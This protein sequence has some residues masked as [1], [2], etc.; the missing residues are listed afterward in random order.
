MESDSWFVGC[1]Y[2]NCIEDPSNYFYDQNDVF[3]DKPGQ[4][5]C[6]FPK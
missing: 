3:R 5:H 1:E 4:T 2:F 6:R